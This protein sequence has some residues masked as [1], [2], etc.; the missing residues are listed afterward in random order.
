M[1]TEKSAAQPGRPV[2]GTGGINRVE[3]KYETTAEDPQYVSINQSFMRRN[4]DLFQKPGVRVLD[5]GCGTGLMASLARDLSWGK[6]TIMGC[7]P[8]A[9]SVEVA[10]QTVK[11]D[12]EREVSFFQGTAKDLSGHIKK[13]SLDVIVIGNAIHEIP[14]EE[15]EEDLK[16]LAEYLADDGVLIWNS[17][18]MEESMPQ[19]V[20]SYWGRWKVETRKEL[21]AG[22][23]R[24]KSFNPLPLIH[25]AKQFNN[26][27]FRMISRHDELVHVGVPLMESI[28]GY[29]TFVEGMCGDFIV[30]EEEVPAGDNY[31]E[32]LI[33]RESQGLI[34][35]IRKLGDEHKVRNPKTELT[36]PRW[37]IEGRLA[38]RASS[39]QAQEAA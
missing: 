19:D 36:Y 14:D 35:S 12:G 1:T 11:S 18:F 2:E 15:R 5:Y 30:P 31:H 29:E 37:W 32:R 21:K 38:K 25:Y 26:A 28:S 8:N 22:R 16:E 9:R 13:G 39:S 4:A 23:D 27:G 34:S 6:A 3:P 10:R 20:M 17:T 7:D 33:A 24:E